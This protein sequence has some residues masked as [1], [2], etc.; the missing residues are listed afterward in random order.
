[1]PECVAIANTN[2]VVLLYYCTDSRGLKSTQIWC[3]YSKN[4]KHP[5]IRKSYHPGFSDRPAY[6]PLSAP[7]GPYRRDSSSLKTRVAWLSRVNV[8]QWLMFLPP[9]HTKQDLISS[10]DFGA[11]ESQVALFRLSGPCS[12]HSLTAQAAQGHFSGPK[13]L[14]TYPLDRFTLTLFGFLGGAGRRCPSHVTIAS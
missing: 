5:N 8:V 11:S 13:F 3:F 4:L 1:M 10:G 2:T 6:P 14:G 12:C 7:I 9:P